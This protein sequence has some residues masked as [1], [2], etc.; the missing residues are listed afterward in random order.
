MISAYIAKKLKKV[1]NFYKKLMTPSKWKYNELIS[2]KLCC[3]D[4]QKIL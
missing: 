3:N 1:S 4:K 2:I